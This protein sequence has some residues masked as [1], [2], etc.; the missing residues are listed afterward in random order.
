MYCKY[1]TWV[2]SLYTALDDRLFSYVIKMN[3]IKSMWNETGKLYSWYSILG[4]SALAF[5]SRL[6]WPWAWKDTLVDFV[7]KHSSLLHML[8]CKL[9]Y[10]QSILQPCVRG[11]CVT[12]FSSSRGSADLNAHGQRSILWKCKC[13]L[14]KTNQLLQW[15]K[16]ALC[17]TYRLKWLIVLIIHYTV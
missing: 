13:N 17:L 8:C 11:L 15:L 6:L 7:F 4:C 9:I 5:Q 12:S 16:Y 1:T 14:F 3:R 10:S 2:G